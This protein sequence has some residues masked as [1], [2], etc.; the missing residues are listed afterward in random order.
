[1][2]KRIVYVYNK[3]VDPK[4]FEGGAAEVVYQQARWMAK[5]TDSEVYLVTSNITSTSKGDYDV[6]SFKRDGIN[7]IRMTGYNI[8]DPHPMRRR[9]VIPNLTSVIHELTENV[10][11]L[12]HFHF[13]ISPMFWAAMIAAKVNGATVTY[14]PHI[15]PSMGY[16]GRER[17]FRD[18]YF[19]TLF[20][21]EGALSDALISV[22]REHVKFL[23][24]LFGYRKKIFV[25]PN[26]IDPQELRVCAKEREV[27]KMFNLKPS[28]RIVLSI[29]KLDKRKDPLTLAKVFRQV[30]KAVPEAKLVFVGKPGNQYVK[31]KQ[32][33]EKCG[34]LKSTVFTSFVNNSVRNALLGM[35]DVYCLLSQYEAFGISVAQAG[36]HYTPA[37]VTNRGGMNDIVVHGETGFIVNFN[38]RVSHAPRYVI[39]LLRNNEL[40]YRMG[41]AARER[42]I[43]NFTWDNEL[44]KLHAV[45]RSLE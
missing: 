44:R 32:F 31:T 9:V 40:L 45:Y 36:Y 8:D 42:V 30:K 21:A 27:R 3:V 43:K 13:H 1:M 23:H 17:I 28:D 26:G 24:E 18:Y 34:L 12:V 16:E 7:F 25:I 6:A 11:S 35:A 20:K 38:R 5:H 19:R 41:L 4:K 29:G 10:R 14:Q 2:H 37:V 33:L 15:H 22:T 39:R